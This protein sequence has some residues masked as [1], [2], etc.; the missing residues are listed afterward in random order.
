VVSLKILLY[1]TKHNLVNYSSE[2]A[3]FLSWSYQRD[4][5]R[6]IALELLLLIKGKE[7]TAKEMNTMGNV[8]RNP[9]HDVTIVGHSGPSYP[10]Q[11]QPATKQWHFTL[12]SA[13][14]HCFFTTLK[15]LQ[16]PEI[17]HSRNYGFICDAI[18]FPLVCMHSKHL[19][20]ITQDQLIRNTV[21]QCAWGQGELASSIHIDLVLEQLLG[22]VIFQAMLHTSTEEACEHRLFAALR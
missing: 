4:T 10:N 9:L 8:L 7:T 20:I 6:A 16:V 17:S 21:S 2:Y 14:P 13:Q 11:N 22:S 12:S 18:F 15:S 5:R 1:Y 3:P 19:A